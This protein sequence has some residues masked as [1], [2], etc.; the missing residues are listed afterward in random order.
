MTYSSMS[1]SLGPVRIQREG[2]TQ[3]QEEQEKEVTGGHYRGCL[4]HKEAAW[5]NTWN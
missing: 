5:A 3:W 4:S 1:E 2:M